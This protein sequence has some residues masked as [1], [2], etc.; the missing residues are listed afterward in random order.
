MLRH[1]ERFLTQRQSDYLIKTYSKSFISY[2]NDTYSF[3]GSDIDLMRDA[4][5]YDLLVK[6]KLI[7]HKDQADILRLQRLQAGFKVVDTHHVHTDPLSLVCFL[8]DDYT[9]GEFVYVDKKGQEI[10]LNAQKNNAIIFSGD[11]PH[12]VNKVLTGDRYTLVGFFSR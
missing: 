1:I 8:N 11:V 12:K 10:E 4:W 9:G 2:I 6:E 7:Q 5:L 3:E